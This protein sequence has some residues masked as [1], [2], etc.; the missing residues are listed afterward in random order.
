M[1]EAS[2]LNKLD[3]YEVTNVIFFSKKLLRDF[4]PLIFSFII[5]K[6]VIFDNLMFWS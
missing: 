1:P 3:S 2:M 6:I 4:T 5:L